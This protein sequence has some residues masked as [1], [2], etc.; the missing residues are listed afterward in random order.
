MSKDCVPTT[1]RRTRINRFEDEN[2]RCRASNRPNPVGEWHGYYNRTR[3]VR[4]LI[5]EFIGEEISGQMEYPAE[6][7]V[8][9]VK[10]VV[11]NRW[12][13]DDPIWAQ[14]GGASH[15]GHWFALAFTRLAMRAEAVAQLVLMVSIAR[16]CTTCLLAR[17]ISA[18]N[19][20]A[21]GRP[22]D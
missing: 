4:L 2:E 8:T 22:S 18:R 20:N 9:S 16:S 15:S 10:G 5:R 1:V 3:P 14:V 7:T 6:G 17:C 19:A 13:P 11:H 21:G 12:S